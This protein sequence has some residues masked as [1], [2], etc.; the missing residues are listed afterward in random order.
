MKTMFLMFV[1]LF[2]FANNQ[3]PYT[4]T[5]AQ[6]GQCDPNN[7]GV[8]EL[9]LKSENPVTVPFDFTLT[10]TGEK[11]IQAQCKMENI[12][13]DKPIIP[14]SEGPVKPGS[15]G[16]SQI[17]ETGKLAT[18]EIKTNKEKVSDSTLE[19]SDET[20]SSDK[21]EATFDSTLENTDEIKS[22]DK[23]EETFD[24]TL[25]NSEKPK[26]FPSDKIN[27][28]GTKEP[29]PFDSDKSDFK[30]SDE[31][32]EPTGFIS[33]S[34][35]D[36]GELSDQMALDS[37]NT[38]DKSRRLESKAYEYSV[39]CTFE[40]P[41]M[42]GSYK[43]DKTDT[44]VGISGDIALSLIPCLSQEEAGARANISLSF[45]QVNKFDK[46]NFKFWF[47]AL[48]SKIIKDTTYSI[49]FNIY[50]LKGLTRDTKLI[51]ITCPI[52][53]G[54]DAEESPLGI[55][56]VSFE[57]SL[58]E[59]T[60]RDGFDSL[61]IDSSEDVAGFPTNSTFLNPVLTDEAIE[62][63]DVKDAA[64]MEIPIF[65]EIEDDTLNFD[66]EKGAMEMK[67]PFTNE[68]LAKDKIHE[69]F[70]IPLAYPSG[71]TLIGKILRFLDKFLYIEFEIKGAIDNQ[72]L[73]WEQNIV[74]IGGDELFVMPGFETEEI[75]T[76][77]YTENPE[78]EEEEKELT[79]D[80]G[81]E[82]GS[83]KISEEGSDKITEE[84]S[85]KITEEGSDKI[86]EGGS[87][88][89]PEEGKSDKIPHEPEKEGLTNELIS[90]L[91]PEGKSDKIPHE[92]EKE[93]QTDEIP[94]PP[95]IPE[96]AEERANMSLSSDKLINLIMK[97]SHF[98][99]ML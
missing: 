12:P 37:T 14:S 61:E 34:T 15:E 82:E 41:E 63:R 2:A 54:T 95:T 3:D 46:E 97:L 94:I 72:P 58:P 92:P 1:L 65:V 64:E 8:L 35:K 42:E 98:G 90:D 51:G 71:V 5:A 80:Q 22:S 53:N 32:E 50:L 79:S 27:P 77:G 23:K 17:P 85:D 43:L 52:K 21:K 60:Q 78:E 48:T 69:T 24:S 20:K 25:E 39:T 68:E 38:I 74:T 18:D 16:L 29:K 4:I 40:P 55:Y 36:E 7:K 59:E 66:L 44:N 84:G 9:I 62:N 91:E 11:E 88:K 81:P 83:D 13:S 45:R 89:I 99:S 67:I 26:P 47:Y 49:T 33:D 76:E 30:P 56:P 19:N 86:P 75:T 10:L 28:E 6:L 87:D 73:I 31:K 96:G 70:E 57:C 93:G